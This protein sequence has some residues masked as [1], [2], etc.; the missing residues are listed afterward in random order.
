MTAL[1]ARLITNRY[2]TP[3]RVTA[4][5]PATVGRARRLCGRRAAASHRV[6]D[7]GRMRGTPGDELLVPRDRGVDQLIQHVI[8]GVADKAGVE[9]ERVTS[10][11]LEPADVAH[12]LDTVR[13]RLDQ[14]HGTSPL[15]ERCPATY[16]LRE[17]GATPQTV[18][19]ADRRR[20]R[21]A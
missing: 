2:S 14:R 17:G 11:L 8:S 7:L 5:S 3:T 15:S 20:S 13:A 10:G 6:D 18:S 4:G 16:L 9:H 21:P 12:G 1:S 19:G